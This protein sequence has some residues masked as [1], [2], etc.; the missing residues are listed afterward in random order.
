MNLS[1]MASLVAVGVGLVGSP[2]VAQR[3][4]RDAAAAPVVQECARLGGRLV[5]T[6]D[7][8]LMM[9]APSGDFSAVL[10]G[11][12]WCAVQF[13]EHL[14]PTFVQLGALAGPGRPRPEPGT[15]VLMV[16]FQ[17][18][19]WPAR[20]PFPTAQALHDALRE[21][22]MSGRAPEGFEA[23]AAGFRARFAAPGYELAMVPGTNPCV[24]VRNS[25]DEP[26]PRG[27][28]LH[29]EIE[30]RICLAPQ[31]TEAG[32][33]VDVTFGVRPA[34]RRSESALRDMS[35]RVFASLRFAADRAET[36]PECVEVK[37]AFEDVFPRCAARAGV[38]CGQPGVAGATQCAE[39]CLAGWLEQSPL[40]EPT[41]RRCYAEVLRGAGFRDALPLEAVL[42]ALR[43]GR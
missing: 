27:G 40:D 11:R 10:P 15:P 33:V 35:G 18:L 23:F 8:R 1:R 16:H 37:R 32:A 19:P 34:D 5:T 36:S 13:R 41:R 20:V 9:H 39:G 2:A 29:T 30:T 31:D 22:Q 28:M 21:Q 3:A 12:D 25:T 6:P 43:Q 7:T 26:M 17:P 14:L 24:A 38:V 4:E 42:R